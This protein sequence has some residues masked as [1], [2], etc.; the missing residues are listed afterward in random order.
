M[1]FFFFFFQGKTLSSPV[2]IQRRSITASTGSYSPGRSLRVG[3]TTIYFIA[4]GPITSASVISGGPL[5]IESPKL[6]IPVNGGIYAST[7]APDRVI[8]VG[9]SVDFPSLFAAGFPGDASSAIPPASAASLEPAG[10]ACPMKSVTLGAVQRSARS[11][12]QRRSISAVLW[13]FI[14]IDHILVKCTQFHPVM[15]LRL[16]PCRQKGGQILLEFPSNIKTHHGELITCGDS[17][18]DAESQAFGRPR[19]KIPM[20]IGPHHQNLAAECALSCTVYWH[21]FVL[22]QFLCLHLFLVFATSSTLNWFG[23]AAESTNRQIDKNGL[24]RAP[25]TLA[26]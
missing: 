15:D 26:V 24:E 22:H 10:G 20:I 12:R 6:D 8:K 5:A 2:G 17:L 11:E 7:P 4:S 18:S 1:V 19:E 23:C 21:S 14:L 25:E 16:H 13:I 9:F 3:T